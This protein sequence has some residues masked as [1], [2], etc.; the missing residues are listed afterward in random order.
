VPILPTLKVGLDIDSPGP[1]QLCWLIRNPTPFLLESI[2]QR[3]EVDALEVA[4]LV[5]LL[6]RFVLILEYELAVLLTEVQL[7]EQRLAD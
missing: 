6:R 1:G 5:R 2:L 3:L 4:G 7:G